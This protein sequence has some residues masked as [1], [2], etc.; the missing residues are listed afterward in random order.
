MSKH[1][2]L[3]ASGETERRALP[4]LVRYLQDQ[5]VVAEDVRIPPRNRALDVEMAAKLIKSAWYE[6]LAAP[7]DKFVV[8]VDVDRA[9]P[10]RALAAMRSQLPARV[11]EIEADVLYAYAQAHLEAWYFADGE[12]LRNFIGRAPGHVDTSMP[13]EI[14]NPK[15]QLRHLLGQ[16]YTARVSAE[17]AGSLDA[18]T[19][20]QRSPSFRAFVAAV[21]NGSADDP[22]AGTGNPA[23]SG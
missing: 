6:N 9:D 11:R 21:L 15:L 3:I 22:S 16:V 1:V 12:N 8:V 19:I 7:P 4:L 23:G 2:I 5:G 13:D 18:A 10:A 17:I 14:D 20:E